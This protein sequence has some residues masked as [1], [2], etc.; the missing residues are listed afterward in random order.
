VWRRTRC[1]ELLTDTEPGTGVLLHHA[2]AQLKEIVTTA[3]KTAER[4]AELATM[5]ARNGSTAACRTSTSTPATFDICFAGCAGA[6]R[7]T[8]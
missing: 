6:E 7:S 5:N 8:R 2:Y 1:T 3:D 4:E